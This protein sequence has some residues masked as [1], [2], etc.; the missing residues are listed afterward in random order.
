MAEA[1]RL[2]SSFPELTSINDDDVLFCM[3]GS[4]SY[5]LPG[6][7]VKALALG[8]SA[9]IDYV[10]NEP[11]WFIYDQDTGAHIQSVKAQGPEGP[12]ITKISINSSYHLIVTLDD[13]TTYDAGYARGPSGSGTGDMLEE[14]YDPGGEIKEEGGIANYVTKKVNAL[15]METSGEF[16]ASGFTAEMNSVRSG[17]VV[18]VRLSISGTPDTTSGGIYVY[19]TFPTPVSALDGAEY[20]LVNL[21][22]DGAVFLAKLDENYL[23][24]R[25]KGASTTTEYTINGAITYIAEPE[26]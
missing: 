22:A 11:Y 26:A 4:V 8:G 17:N 9:Y 16:E 3:R 18:V 5:K 15:Q 23:R 1:T 25:W 24:V 21:T 14:D 6:S 10:N 13:G 12:R 19:D 7:V 20:P 2:I